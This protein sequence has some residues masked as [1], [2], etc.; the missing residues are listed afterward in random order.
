M[1]T[2]TVD[3][4]SI[5]LIHTEANES[6]EWAADGRLRARLSI[7]AP[8]RILGVDS[9][10]GYR[11]SGE[12]FENQS[13]IR[14]SLRTCSN[15]RHRQ[16]ARTSRTEPIQQSS[17]TAR[18]VVINRRS[19]SVLDSWIRRCSV[20]E[21]CRPPSRLCRCGIALQIGGVA[22]LSII[23]RLCDGPVHYS[24][25]RRATLIQ[26]VDACCCLCSCRS[27]GAQVRAIVQQPLFRC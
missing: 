8:A 25:V 5:A 24:I 9:G 3:P 1:W 17:G 11:R 2:S 12:T 20:I 22:S 16:A 26:R 6:F 7:R 18:N 13:S 27:C 19:C 10:H 14:D 21:H 4:I 15:S 23:G